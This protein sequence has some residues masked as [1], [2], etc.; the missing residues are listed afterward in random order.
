MGRR[1][2]PQNIDG[3]CCICGEPCDAF[4][5]CLARPFIDGK[6]YKEICFCCGSVPAPKKVLLD[7]TEICLAGTFTQNLQTLQQMIND[8]FDEYQATKSIKAVGKLTGLSTRE[9]NKLL[10]SNQP[11][12]NNPIAKLSRHSKTAKTIKTPKQARRKKYI[13]KPSKIP[14]IPK[15]IKGRK[16]D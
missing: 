7:K 5:N 12:T 1:K 4:I 15:K 9:I 3:N 11:K 6:R 13:Q 2:K 14:K 16:N 10:K 8:G